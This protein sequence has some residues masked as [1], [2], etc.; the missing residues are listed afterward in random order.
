MSRLKKSEAEIVKSGLEASLSLEEFK[1][2]DRLPSTFDGI[3]I[4][5]SQKCAYL[6]RMAD[7]GII[8]AKWH[9]RGWFKWYSYRRLRLNGND[10]IAF[11]KPADGELPF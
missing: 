3:W 11:S 10:G 6:R 9:E 7:A 4:S 1:T 5:Q 2:P 8:Q